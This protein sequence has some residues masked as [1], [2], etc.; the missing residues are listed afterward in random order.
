MG[1]RNDIF[2][3]KR[4]EAASPRGRLSLKGLLKRNKLTYAVT[5][6]LKKIPYPVLSGW[7][8][9]CHWR[10]GVEGD[11]VFFSSYD[12]TLYNDNPRAVAEALHAL[13]PDLKLVFRLNARGRRMDL[14]DWVRVAPGLSLETLRELATSGA[15][16]TNAGMKRWMVKFLD[17]FY[18][19]TWHGDRGFKRIYLD[20]NPRR[21]YYLKEVPRIDLAVSGSAFGSRVYRSAMGVKGEILEQGCPRNDVLVQN[22]PALARRVRESLGIP[23]G[24]RVLMY[25][26]TFR[27]AD[28]GGRQAARL[29][30]EKALR[31]LEAATGERWRC[32]TRSHEVARGIAADAGVD[33]SDYPETTELLLITDLLIT[34]YSSIGGDFMLLNRPVV[35]YQPDRAEY[36]RDRGGLY[37][38]PDHSPLKVVH[39]EQALLDLLAHPFDPAENCR[40]ALAFFGA[41][42]TGRAAEAVAE[43]IIDALGV[44]KG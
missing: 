20:V 13:C 39:S 37:F 33:V 26:P 30:L 12:G 41:N 7:M 1:K 21:R 9:F 22:P 14:P 19:Q 11:K 2:G 42:E 43:R 15:I 17:Q 16:V 4:V 3:L 36:D 29:S 32:I 31:A 35:Y 6:A 18:V 34:D 23:E 8:R 44:K 5:S 25:A 40:E 38:D 24:E 10:Y 28:T 27:E